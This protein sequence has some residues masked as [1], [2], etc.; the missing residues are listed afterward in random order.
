MSKYTPRHGDPFDYPDI[1]GDSGLSEAYH[2]AVRP[3]HV[4]VLIEKRRRLREQATAGRPGWCLIENEGAL[5]RGP[6]RS[7]PVEVWSPEAGWEPY[8]GADRPRGVEWG[9]EISEL[10]A[11]RLICER[12]AQADNRR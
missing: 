5:F 2:D 3:E 6:G 9:Y 7:N 10:D 11:F 4:K 8:A 1:P 12:Q